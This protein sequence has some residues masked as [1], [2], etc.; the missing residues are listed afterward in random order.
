VCGE[1]NAFYNGAD[2]WLN[3]KVHSRNFFYHGLKKLKSG[4]ISQYMSYC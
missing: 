3:F 4:I 1:A 2:D